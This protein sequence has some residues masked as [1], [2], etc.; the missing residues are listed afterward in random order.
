MN[1]KCLIGNV[2]GEEFCIQADAENISSFITSYGYEKNI[3]LYTLHGYPLLTTCGGFLDRCYDQDFLRNELM[4]VFLPMQMGETAPKETVFF[5]N[6]QELPEHPAPVPD[7]DCCSGHGIY[8]RDDVWTPS[9]EWK[10]EDGGSFIASGK[11][12][13]GEVTLENE[14]EEIE[15]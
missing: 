3:I 13:I 1:Q 7:W 6:I 15:R 8:N 4:P 5:N 14:E 11:E 12:L 2:C 9:R 10:P